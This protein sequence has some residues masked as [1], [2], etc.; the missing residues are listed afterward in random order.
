[1]PSEVRAQRRTADREKRLDDV[2]VVEHLIDAEPLARAE[3]L[4]TSKHTG[5]ALAE[6][7]EIS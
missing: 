1:M 5:V 6:S 3:L 2:S 7:H 4:E